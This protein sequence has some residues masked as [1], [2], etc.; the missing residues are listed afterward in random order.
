MVDSSSAVPSVSGLPYTVPRY[1]EP[2]HHSLTDVA[3]TR[4][5]SCHVQGAGTLAEPSSGYDTFRSSCRPNHSSTSSIA[6]R[7]E[8]TQRSNAS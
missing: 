1:I 2:C 4:R 7:P 8:H 5:G 6:K 3:A